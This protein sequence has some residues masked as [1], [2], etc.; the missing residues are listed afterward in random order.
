MYFVITDVS[1]LRYIVIAYSMSDRLSMP[2][3]LSWVYE[4][5]LRRVWFLYCGQ[6][7]FQK[8]TPRSKTASIRWIKTMLMYRPTTLSQS[9]TPWVKR[10]ERQVPQNNVTAAGEI[11][12]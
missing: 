7:I 8:N 9:V 2:L 1:K 5:A 10:A 6:L 4:D 12:I 11:L 3:G